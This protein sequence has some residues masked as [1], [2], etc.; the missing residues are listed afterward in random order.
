MP[1]IN[2]KNCKKN[3]NSSFT[4][5]ITLLFC[6]K[7]TT[8][9][10]STWCHNFRIDH[11]ENVK[12]HFF[13]G[14]PCITLQVPFQGHICGSDVPKNFRLQHPGIVAHWIDF[15]P[16]FQNKVHSSLGCLLFAAIYLICTKGINPKFATESMRI[17]AF[18]T[19][20]LD[21]ISE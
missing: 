6:T 5:P 14:W 16:P 10:T 18:Q 4:C 21:L 7:I 9:K 19:F 11:R 15:K 13:S 20:D 1:S 8:V 3:H 17:C 12:V 2:L